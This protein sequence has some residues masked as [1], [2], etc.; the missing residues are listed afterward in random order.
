M[1]NQSTNKDLVSMKLDRATQI[2]HEASTI[3]EARHIISLAVAA[4]V[5]GRQEKLGQEAVRYAKEIELRAK[6]KLG[7]ILKVS[8][9]A[10]GGQHGGK[11]KI[12]GTRSEPSNPIP[13]YKEIKLDKKLAA[14]AQKLADIP[15]ERFERFLKSEGLDAHALL[16]SERERAENWEHKLQKARRRW[17]LKNM[18]RHLD[19]AVRFVQHEWNLSDPPLEDWQ[20]IG[21]WLID[22][23]HE[24][25]DLRTSESCG[26]DVT[27]SNEEIYG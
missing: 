24:W 26:M 25:N 11:K 21:Q 5:Y 6:R 4:Q 8:P 9:K 3:Q 27:K 23:G 10:S 15:D 18:I 7:Q 16:R 2:L 14:R 12:D 19:K 17:N 22:R 1:K 13:T 20:V